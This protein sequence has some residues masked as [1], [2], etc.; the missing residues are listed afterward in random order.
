MK[1]VIGITGGIA[2][3][4]SYVSSFLIKKGYAVIDT[5]KIC[6]LLYEPYEKGWLE[7]KNSFPEVFI[8]DQLDRK[9]L[10][11]MIFDSLEKRAKLNSILHPLIKEKTKEMIKE[12]PTDLVFVD[13]PLLF[14]AHF[15]DLCDKII[16]VA[17]SPNNQLKRLMMRDNLTKEEA[18]KRIKAQF[19]L[20]KKCALSDYVIESDEDFGKTEMNILNV[21]EKIRSDYNGENI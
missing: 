19:S 8:D 16:C 12:S 11:Q 10:G 15:D 2:T 21:L 1:K 18:L 4:K 3:G 17:T 7:V 9:K 13:V 20:E 14:E 5:D 6:H